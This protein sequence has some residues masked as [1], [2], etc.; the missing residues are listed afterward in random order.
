MTS[1]IQ[2]STFTFDGGDLPD[3]KVSQD[4]LPKKL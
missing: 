3:W 1:S 4:T 2:A